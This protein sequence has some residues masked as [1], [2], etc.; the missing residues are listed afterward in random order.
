[1]IVL[2]D[3]NCPICIKNK[4]FVEKKD[5][6]NLLKFIDIHSNS[7]YLEK[8]KSDKIKS[9]IHV[10][11]NDKIITGMN[12]IR[13]IYKSIGYHKFIKITTIPIL[14]NIFNLSYKII[15]KN[16]LIISKI[17]NFFNKN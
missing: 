7:S 12:A 11:D 3:G 4:L 8:I 6:K 15:S 5:D 14:K 1:M 16:R 10:I 13:Y 2:Y 9:Q 17:M